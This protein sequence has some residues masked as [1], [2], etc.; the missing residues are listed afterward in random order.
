[1]G[2]VFNVITYSKQPGQAAANTPVEENVVLSSSS[3]MSLAGGVG[4][5]G[6]DLFLVMV[7]FSALCKADL[8]LSLS[9]YKTTCSSINAFIASSLQK[10]NSLVSFALGSRTNTSTLNDSHRDV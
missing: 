8:T 6:G 9:I 7:S 3:L 1:L 4:G 2:F 10:I 5:G